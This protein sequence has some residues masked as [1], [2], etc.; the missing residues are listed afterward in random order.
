MPTSSSTTTT[1]TTTSAITTPTTTGTSSPTTTITTTPLNGK[2]ECF[3]AGGDGYITVEQGES[4]T[5]QT[6][7]IEAMVTKCTGYSGAQLAWDRGLTQGVATL[8]AVQLSTCQA[9]AASLNA[10]LY[11]YSME[12]VATTFSCSI[13]GHIKT[14]SET[15]CVANVDLLAR[16]IHHWSSGPFQDCKMT[17]STLTTSSATTTTTTPSTATAPPSTFAG[18]ATDQRHGTVTSRFVIAGTQT[19]PVLDI[20]ARASAG[21]T[22]TIASGGDS[23]T[24]PQRLRRLP[25]QA[26][27]RGGG[28]VHQA[29]TAGIFT[30]ADALENGYPAGSSILVVPTAAAAATITSPPPVL[31][32]ASQNLFGNGAVDPALLGGGIAAGVFLLVLVALLVYA[33]F[34]THDNVAGISEDRDADRR[35]SMGVMLQDGPQS[36]HYIKMSKSGCCS[37]QHL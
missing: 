29:A 3:N 37:R 28:G 6:S 19:I 25:Q 5:A 34:Y 23:E 7:A 11:R 24:T 30:V 27:P 9:I 15:Q 31:T 14:D 12:Q 16:A 4:C 35:A 10:V 20:G 26:S 18:G 8:K 32:S 1:A 21:D 2:L 33:V 22:L 36:L 13:G 17:T